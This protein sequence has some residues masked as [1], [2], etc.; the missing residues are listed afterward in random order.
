MD[1]LRVHHVDD[2]ALV[3]AH[4]SLLVG[5]WWSSTTVAHLRAFRDCARELMARAPKFAS[6]V[7]AMDSDGVFTFSEDV[8]RVATEIVRETESAGAGTALVVLRRGFIG[9]A[10]RAFLPGVFLIARSKEPQKVFGDVPAAATWLA[11]CL[12]AAEPH[13]GWSSEG[14]G[15]TLDRTMALAEEARRG[16]G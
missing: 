14:V 3:A 2:G 12:R 5:A 15:A 1:A 13:G 7:I 4:R 11:A 6:A 16:A 8:R 9:A 10:V